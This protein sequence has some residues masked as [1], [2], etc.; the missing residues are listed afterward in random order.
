M[1]SRV[2]GAPSG[3]APEERCTVRDGVKSRADRPGWCQEKER[4]VRDDAVFCC[5]PRGSGDPV[6]P[7]RRRYLRGARLDPGSALRAVRDD[8]KRRGPSGMTSKEGAGRAG[9]RQKRGAPSGMTSMGRDGYS[10]FVVIPAEAGIQSP[11]RGA[12]TCGVPVWIP[13]RR[14]ALSGMTSRVRSAP[15]GMRNDAV[16]AVIPAEAGIQD[17]CPGLPHFRRCPECRDK[18]PAT[19]D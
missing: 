15:C 5:H 3:M 2:R 17:A 8:I 10:F 11:P 14:C 1:T 7:A 12:G 4:A 6:A 9:W 19:Q 18:G 16:F 13:A